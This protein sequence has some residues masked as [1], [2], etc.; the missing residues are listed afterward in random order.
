MKAIF[1]VIHFIAKD[2][3]FWWL[4]QYYIIY[5][6]NV[7]FDEINND[8]NIVRVIDCIAIYKYISNAK[9]MVIKDFN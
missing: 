4:I 2:F 3:I 7:K 8:N 6:V 1:N 9:T 5:I